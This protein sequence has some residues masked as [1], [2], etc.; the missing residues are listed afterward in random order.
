M[1]HFAISRL[2][3]ASLWIDYVPSE[4]NPADV[5]SRFHEMRV[6]ERR[7]ASA[8]LGDWVR[9]VVPELSDGRGSWLSSKSI[10]LSVWGA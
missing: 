3:A 8:Q 10:A 1:F 4:S 5:P 6:E 2:G 9:M 7:V